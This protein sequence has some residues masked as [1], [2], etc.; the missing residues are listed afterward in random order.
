MSGIVVCLQLVLKPIRTC[1]CLSP[2]VLYPAWGMHPSLCLAKLWVPTGF[3]RF[4]SL[5]SLSPPL[6]VVSLVSLIS[7]SPKSAR[8]EGVCAFE[9][10]RNQFIFW[11]LLFVVVSLPLLPFPPFSA[12]SCALCP[13][14][15]FSLG[16]LRIIRLLVVILPA[17]SLFV[18]VI[19]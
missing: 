3:R 17:S 9:H 13:Y 14:Y 7:S 1:F 5:S 2:L 4:L 8:I 15:C 16:A 12:C 19:S 10:V 6:F 18:R 11:P